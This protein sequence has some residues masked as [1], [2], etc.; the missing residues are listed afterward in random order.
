MTLLLSRA[1]SAGS[2]PLSCYLTLADEV[3]NIL[4]SRRL[5]TD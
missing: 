3:Y 1:L 4:T 5:A 2:G